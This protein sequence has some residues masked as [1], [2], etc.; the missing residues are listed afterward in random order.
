MTT[1]KRVVRAK[2]Q[3]PVEI[4]KEDIVVSSPAKKGFVL[5][6]KKKKLLILVLALVVAGLAA[7]RYKSAFVVALVNRKPITRMELNRELQKQYGE[8]TLQNLITQRLIL[9]EAEQQ[10]VDIPEEKVNTEI[11]AA[12][13]EIEAQ[14]GKLEDFLAMQGQTLD[15]VK[16]QIR[17]RLII[18]EILGRDIEVTDEEAQEYFEENTSFF[19]EG[20]EF[21]DVKE[22]VKNQ[23][24][25]TKISEKFQEWITNLR[26]GAQIQNFIQS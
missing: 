23:L 14:G 25:T 16:E 6:Q 12:R 26:N 24:K 19:P 7:Y 15:S 17:I 13:T 11:D 1:R 5:D 18:E 2:K 4:V 20:T 8:E 10:N 22:D 9:E 21:E 3:E